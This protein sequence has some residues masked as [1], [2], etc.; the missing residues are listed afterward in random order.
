MRDTLVETNCSHLFSM[1]LSFF[2]VFIVVLPLPGSLRM[3]NNSH[4]CDTLINLV[5]FCDSPL[6]ETA[7]RG[8]DSSRV[9]PAIIKIII[10]LIVKTVHCFRLMP[11]IRA[12]RLVEGPAVS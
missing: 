7:L 4:C 11:D 6:F 5:T 12:A 3:E 2:S 1:A 10:H 8:R 9:A